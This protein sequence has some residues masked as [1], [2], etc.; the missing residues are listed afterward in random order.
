VY[1][2]LAAIAA[3]DKRRPGDKGRFDEEG[4]V[5]GI[6]VGFGDGLR[7]IWSDPRTCAACSGS[8]WLWFMRQ[9]CHS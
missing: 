5:E 7:L 9:Y 4:N 8:A 6:V 1:D 3:G 2:C